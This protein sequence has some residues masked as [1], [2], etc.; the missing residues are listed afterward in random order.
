ML[1][2]RQVDGQRVEAHARMR[3]FAMFALGLLGD[4]PW[5]QDPQSKDGRSDVQL[6]LAAVHATVATRTRPSAWRS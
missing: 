2:D 3:Q 4:Q 5:H 6:D 1:W